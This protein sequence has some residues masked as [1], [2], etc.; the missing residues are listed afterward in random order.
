M[1]IK[2]A[3]CEDHRMLADALQMV[4]EDEEG[5]ELVAKPVDTAE[6]AV[7]VVEAF[8]PDVVLM[9]IQLRG[10]RTGIDATREI[11]RLSPGTQVVIVSGL[12]A[13]RML[14]EAVEAGACGFL[15]K[16]EAVEEAI[17]AVRAAAAG[18]PLIDPTTLSRLLRQA[19]ENRE[20]T[21]G[22]DLMI[23]QLTP[24]EK[25]MLQ[26]LS[27]GMRNEEIA[28][29]LHLSVRTVQTHVQNI[30]GKLG[31]HS[32]LEAVAFAARAGLVKVGERPAAAP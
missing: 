22:A 7:A 6:D 15:D 8:R 18:E 9:D 28:T 1:T 30:L 14:V 16:T 32:R 23:A 10:A 13:E 27:Q 26:L 21:R 20:A 31:V 2:L 24:R 3:I 19:A 11:R 5:I 25:E 12:G 17:A 4:I 29:S